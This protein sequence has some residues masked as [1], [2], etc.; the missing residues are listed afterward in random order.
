[1]VSLRPPGAVEETAGSRALDPVAVL[2]QRAAAGP[3]AAQRNPAPT[4]VDQRQTFAPASSADA[5]APLPLP[6]SRPPPGPAAAPRS[7]I[8][9]A[10]PS[11]N[12]APD[13]PT[14]GAQGDLAEAFWSGLG[15]DSAQ[16]PPQ[17]RAELLAEC[18]RALREAVNGLVPVL[19]AR[20]SLKDE[21]RMDQ[22]RL[23]PK[24]NN[25]LKFLP[26]G[27]AVLQALVERKLTGFLPLSLAVREGFNDIRAHEVAA[28]V[29]LDAVIKNLLARFDPAS[30]DAQGPT[31]KLFGKGP[32]KTKLWDNFVRVHAALAGNLEETTRKVVGEEFA[33]AYAQ[34]VAS[35]RHGGN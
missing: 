1:M 8:P 5:I 26:S 35:T 32:D 16:V 23:Q 30:M 25:P 17:M 6:G 15:L 34:Q 2:R 11:D 3:A 12:R 19:T 14:P 31:T 7:S 4:L 27:E 28:V 22:T 9:L 21:L 29:A 33:R 24:E 20:R 18:G 10:Q 13:G